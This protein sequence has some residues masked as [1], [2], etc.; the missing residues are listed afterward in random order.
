MHCVG[1][2]IG[3]Q[4]AFIECPS[5]F[6]LKNNYCSYWMKYFPKALLH[7]I[8]MAFPPE[9][10]HV[11]CDL[12]KGEWINILCYVIRLGCIFNSVQYLFPICT[13]CMQWECN[14]IGFFLFLLVCKSFLNCHCLNCCSD[15][16]MQ[17]CIKCDVA[18]IIQL[19]SANLD[20]R[21]M[22]QC[23]AHWICLP[24]LL[25]A[26]AINVKYSTSHGFWK[27]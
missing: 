7:K 3:E 15:K 6:P 10:L 27:S 24:P 26:L 21:T 25:H 11:G 12:I 13:N 17:W 22:F 4:W 1:N 5:M 20:V 18:H 9:Y 8:H 2:V 19:L 14:I 23:T 16:M